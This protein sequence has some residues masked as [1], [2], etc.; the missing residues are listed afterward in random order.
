M[1]RSPQEVRVGLE[2][3]IITF[4]WGW[5]RRAI[6]NCTNILLASVCIYMYV[7]HRGIFCVVKVCHRKCME[8]CFSASGGTCIYY[9]YMYCLGILHIARCATMR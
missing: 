8:K 7:A 6:H 1:L 3:A 9:I 4:L 5:G 2:C